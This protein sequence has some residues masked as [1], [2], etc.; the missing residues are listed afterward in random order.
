[1]ALR[2]N[3]LLE[4]KLS[5]SA[6][7]NARAY[8]ATRDLNAPSLFPIYVRRRGYGARRNQ[9]FRKDFGEVALHTVKVPRS[10]PS[11]H[12]DE[13]FVALTR[14]LRRLPVSVNT[15]HSSHF[16]ILC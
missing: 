12:T 3:G 11:L 2:E 14:H 13:E 9:K 6:I 1:M 16:V 8:A 5:F 10:W 15:H 7:S 4:F